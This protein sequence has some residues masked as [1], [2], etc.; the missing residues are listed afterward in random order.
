LPQSNLALSAQS[1]FRRDV[2]AEQE[3]VVRTQG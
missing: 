1:I 3:K 2:G